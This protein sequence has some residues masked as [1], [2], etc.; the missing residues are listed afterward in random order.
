[1][2]VT[3]YVMLEMG[4]PLHAFDLDR[5][6]GASIVVRRPRPGETLTTLDNVVRDLKPHMLVIA[7][8][9]KPVALAGMMGG[10]ESEITEQTKT[11]LLESAMFAGA[12]IFQTSRELGLRSES[13]ARF[14]KGL[15]I[16]NTR[17]AADRAAQLM[18]EMG[19]GKVLKGCVDVCVPDIAPRT[20]EYAASRIDRYLGTELSPQD[21]AELL[22]RLY[23]GV[24]IMGDILRITVPS[25]RNDVEIM[26]DV[27]E[28]IA[29]LYG[30]DNIPITRLRGQVPTGGRTVRQ[31][32]ERQVKDALASVGLYESVTWSFMSPAAWQKLGYTEPL[33][34]VRVAN[35]LGEDQ[36]LMRT[37]L[38][39]N[40]FAA[41]LYNKN[42]Q[43]EEVGLFEVSRTY[44]PKA[45]PLTEL[46]EEI[47]RLGIVLWGPKADY[48][49]LK[50]KVEALLKRL[51]L[52]D[53]ARFERTQHPAFHPGRSA[54]LW[55][56]QTEI[57]V[58]G[59]IHPYT[60]QA[61]DIP[62]TALA[63]ELNLTL[64]YDRAEE[65][66]DVRAQAPP[67]YPAVTRDLALVVDA[68]IPSSQLQ[69]EIVRSGGPQLENVS[70]FDVYQGDNLPAGKKSLAYALRFR[71]P[72]RTLQD[73]DVTG[74]MQKI[75]R[76]LEQKLGAKLR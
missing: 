42:R 38:L 24:E 43:Q 11:V 55:I 14:E 5:V 73:E 46:P 15:D 48:F 16:V 52:D 28:E 13:S 40:L 27:A 26:E 1:M 72:D 17:V 71:D 67:R 19:A 62:D 50:G 51:H 54:A 47:R 64:L 25:F 2:D 6:Q 9:E 41:L 75:V 56:G 23:F 74:R 18:E 63:A 34:A 70:L 8:A 45:L 30:Y 4:Q 12:S 36:S 29:R 21:M 33:D 60:A 68:D 58:L 76:T 61:F 59:Q 44:H 49:E 3:N 65:K 20:I 22:Q 39:P 35:A 10:L 32:L 31:N 66:G 7:D 53:E 69:Q 37:T 57:G